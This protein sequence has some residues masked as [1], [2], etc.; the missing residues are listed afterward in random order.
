MSQQDLISIILPIY[1]QADHIG[2]V[3]QEYAR[4]LKKVPRPHE[5]LLVVNNCRDRSLEVCQ[6]L[7]AQFPTVRVIHS[8]KGGWGLAVKLGLR[9]AKG[10]L[11]CYTN[12]AR[13]TGKDLTLVLL[14]AVAYSDVVIKADRKIRDSWW[15]RLGSLGYNLECRALFDMATWDVNGTPKIFPRS[16]S[17]LLDLKED[18]DLIDAEFGAICRLENYPVLEVPILSSRRHGGTSTTGLRTAFR[19]YSGAY[20]LSKKLPRMPAG[21]KAE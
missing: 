1:N 7:V 16:F 14:Y 17:R 8:Q 11:L 3:V 12:S 6:E 10:D 2:E 13:T 20:Q 4:S 18:G 19:L 9:E 21:Q 5:L 15:R